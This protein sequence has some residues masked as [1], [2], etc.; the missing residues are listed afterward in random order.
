M[1]TIYFVRHGESEGNIG[2]IRQT[3]SAP[4]T[5]KG[6][7]QAHIIA[8]RCAKIPVDIL[9][10]STMERA[11]QTTLIISEKIQTPVEYSE[12]FIERRRPSEVLGQP[13][14]SPEAKEI[15]NLI[16]ENFTK[17]NWKFSDE[18]NF[19]DLKQRALKSLEYITQKSEENILVVTHGY[20]LKVIAA[21]ILL[22]EN[23]TSSECQKILENLAPVHNTGI[24]VIK[25]DELNKNNPWNIIVWNDYSHLG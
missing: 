22:G 18:E 19:A 12:L 20:F 8:D 1:K 21:C 4:L 13:K 3:A 17:P 10:S 5:E 9:L 16:K 7:N 24:T 25:Y 6:I 15:N 11:K 14:E 23:I 2:P